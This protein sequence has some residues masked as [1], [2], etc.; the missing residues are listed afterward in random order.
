MPSPHEVAIRLMENS[1]ITIVLIDESGF[2]LFLFHLGRRIGGKLLIV[3][4][5]FQDYKSQLERRFAMSGKTNTRR[6][7]SE[8]NVSAL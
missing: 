7:K 1:D 3:S 4:A 2:Y 8:R 6:A 5:I